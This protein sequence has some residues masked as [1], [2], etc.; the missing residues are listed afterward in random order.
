MIDLKRLNHYIFLERFKMESL[1]TIICVIQPGDWMLSIDMQDAYLHITILPPFQKYLRF[2][3]WQVH[4]QFQ[5]LLSGPCTSPR[6][7]TKTLITVIAPLRELG[8]RVYYYLDD[9]LL[10]VKYPPAQLVEHKSVLLS[11][12]AEFGCKINQEKNHLSLTQEMVYLGALF[13]TMNGTVSLTALEGDMHYLK[14]EETECEVLRDSFE[15]PEPDRT[16][17]IMYPY[18][19]FSVGILEALEQTTSIPTHTPNKS[20]A[21]ESTLVDCVH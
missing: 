18:G 20:N 2:A 10:L 19:P 11:T 9:I 15:L 6:V 17:V 8:L 7:F 14:D 1:Q 16:D 21:Q 5:S 4:L 3:V 12:L 13:N